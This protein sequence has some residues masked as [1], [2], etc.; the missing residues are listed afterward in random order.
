MPAQLEPLGAAALQRRRQRT[1]AERAALQRHRLVERWALG[2]AAPSLQL[3]EADRDGLRDRLRL[4][5]ILTTPEALALIPGHDQQRIAA[6]DPTGQ[7]F[8]PDRLRVTLGPK[9]AA[10]IAL[11]LPQLLARFS[12]GEVIAA[13]DPAVLALHATATAHH[14]QL[15]AATGWSPGKLATGTLRTLLQAC[16]WKLQRVGRIKA[17]GARRDALTYRAQRLALPEGVDA[18]A[19]AA[20]WLAEL[21]AAAT[22][23][24]FT[25]TRDFCRGRKCPTPPDHGPPPPHRPSAWG[26]V[27]PIA[28]AAAL[29]SHQ[30]VPI[31]A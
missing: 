20:A 13:T 21:Q 26:R 3:L 29:R 25:P 17:R 12:A 27:V 2:T 28:W 4:G 14:A 23:A 6:L 5:W 24:L 7:P 8:A 18:K 30:S 15:V 16:G 31:A 19:L 11:G 9:V 1:P 10:L 22:G